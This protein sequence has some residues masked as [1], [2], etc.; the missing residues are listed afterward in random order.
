MTLVKV[1]KFVVGE[2][3][4]VILGNQEP[5]LLPGQVELRVCQPEVGGVISAGAARAR[6]SSLL[7]ERT[8]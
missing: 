1:R 6:A 8:L 4:S 7:L 2:H 3:N 5:Q